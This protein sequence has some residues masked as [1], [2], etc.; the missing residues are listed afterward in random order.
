MVATWREPDV[1]LPLPLPPLDAAASGGRTGVIKPHVGGA[2][3]CGAGATAVGAA[4][5]PP[6][7]QGRLQLHDDGQTSR[8]HVEDRI[9]EDEAAIVGRIR[10]T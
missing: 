6:D 9:V 4:P 8:H 5:H 2:I 10:P 3:Q 7:V 1:R